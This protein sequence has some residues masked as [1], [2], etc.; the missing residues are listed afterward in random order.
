MQSFVNTPSTTGITSRAQHWASELTSYKH[1]LTLWDSVKLVRVALFHE[2]VI[3]SLLGKYELII[4][5]KLHAPSQ[6]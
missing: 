2:S 6:N 4:K 1:H 5:G 3:S